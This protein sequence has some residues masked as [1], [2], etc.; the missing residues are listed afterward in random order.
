MRDYGLALVTGATSGIG[1]AFVEALPPETGLLLTGRDAQALERLGA[2]YGVGG[3]RVETLAADLAVAA[4]VRALI[5]RAESLN[6][7]LLINNAGFGEFGRFVENDP[8]RELDMIAVN[9]TAV[10]ALTRALLPGMTARAKENSARAGLIIVSSTVALVPTPMLA[11]YAGTKSFELSWAEAVAEEMRSEPVDLLVLC[12]GATRTNFFR[13][14]G[15]PESM[16]RF[17]ERPDAVARKAL[18]LLGRR[19]VL[20]S[21]RPFR[22][23]LG[24]QTL[25]RRMMTYGIARYLERAGRRDG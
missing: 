1:A 7:D 23:A 9:V 4:D 3:R 6:V 22:F 14:G 13:R 11:T 24:S 25:P 8:K 20:V 21:Q 17:A 18:R 10:V 12:P 15:L 5:E 16:L 19:R 2:R